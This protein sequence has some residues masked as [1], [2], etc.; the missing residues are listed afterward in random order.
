MTFYKRDAIETVIPY[1]PLLIIVVIIFINTFNIV[2]ILM[3][4]NS[5]TYAYVQSTMNSA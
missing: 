2:A 1:A 4:L 5:D 3:I